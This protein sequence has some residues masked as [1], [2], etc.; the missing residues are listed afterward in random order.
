MID[1]LLN[2]SKEYFTTNSFTA[3]VNFLSVLG[4]IVTVYVG[5][6]VRKIKNQFVAKVRVPELKSQLNLHVSTLSG[7]LND[8]KNNSN[9][10]DIEIARIEPVLQA[11]KKRFKWSETVKIKQTLKLLKNRRNV[12]GTRDI[13]N[14]LHGVIAEL[15]Q[16][17]NDKKWGE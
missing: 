11:I 5:F 4:F 8:Y 3:F 17:E 2:Y 13:F 6:G 14:S 10:I 7:Y 16:W 9:A 12:D 15:E 1:F